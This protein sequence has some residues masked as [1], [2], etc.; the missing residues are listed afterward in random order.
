MRSGSIV[1]PSY[2]GKQ[3]NRAKLFLLGNEITSTQ[4]IELG[5]GVVNVMRLK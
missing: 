5:L 1:R 4:K 2:D 3:L